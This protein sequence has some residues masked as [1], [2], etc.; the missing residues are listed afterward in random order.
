MMLSVARS[1]PALA[2]ALAA[3]GVVLP[4]AA[5]P[6]VAKATA[7]GAVAAR[8]AA[9]ASQPERVLCVLPPSSP[10]ADPSLRAVERDACPLPFKDALDGAVATRGN[11]VQGK[12]MPPEIMGVQRRFL[13]LTA[14]SGGRR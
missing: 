1:L 6:A 3:A 11:R 7:P 13:S 14:P 10:G 5:A 9:A 4:A 12:Q 2:I 8:P